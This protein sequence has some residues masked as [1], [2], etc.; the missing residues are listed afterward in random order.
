MTIAEAVA[1]GRKTRSHTGEQL[2]ALG[3]APTPEEHRGLVQ[4]RKFL[5]RYS[6]NV[7]VRAASP[8]DRAQLEEFAQAFAPREDLFRDKY[9]A[10]RIAAHAVAFFRLTT[11]PSPRGRR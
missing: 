2:D 10:D 3:I 8:E 1:L 5:E 4:L 6:S 7:L 9:V 11:P